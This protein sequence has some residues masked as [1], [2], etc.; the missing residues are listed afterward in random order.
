M[1]IVI[2]G[3]LP[4]LNM[5][6]DESKKHWTKYRDMKQVE[7]EK[8]AWIA[9]KLPKMGKIDLK[10]T[11]YCKDKRKDKDNILVGIKFI[12]DGLVEA[13]IIKNDGWK[14]VG[15]ITPKFEIDK[16]NPRIEV[17]ISEVV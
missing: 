3:E 9:K 6:I 17:L 15:D 8:V 10:I 4:D 7:T 11:W 14:E 1:K 2:P 16:H 5:I 13:G 12:L